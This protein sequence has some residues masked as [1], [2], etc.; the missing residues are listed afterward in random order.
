MS[1][2]TSHDDATA[3][4]T[5]FATK[6]LMPLMNTP[7]APGT[8]LQAIEAME[9]GARRDIAQAEYFYFS[10]QP[11]RAL[12]TAAPYLDSQDVAARL[13]AC[14]ICAYANLPLDRAHEAK[15]LLDQMNVILT[16]A[17]ERSPQLG[18]ASAFV[19]ATAAVL[20]HLRSLRSCPTPTC[21]RRFSQRVCALLRST[22]RRT[23]STSRASTPSAP[24]SW[25]QRCSWVPRITPFRPSTCASLPSW[26]T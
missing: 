26:T 10:G 17:G 21:S 13:S 9:L 5:P 8:H 15:A 16:K 22:C 23:C 14:Q 24:A 4:G 3:K 1:G 11:E 2:M 25:R 18:A 12:A 7:F 20:L 19:S 6:T